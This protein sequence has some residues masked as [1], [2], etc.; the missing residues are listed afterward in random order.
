MTTPT[1]DV[2]TIGEGQIRL[3][4]NRGERLMS[5]RSVRMNPACSEANVA[6]LLSELKRKTLWTSSL[7]EGDL[8]EYVLSEYRSVGV[9]LSTMVRKPTSRIALYFMEPGEPPM[10]ANVIYDREYTPFRTTGIDEYDWDTILDT[11][12]IF[13]TGITAALT[14]TTADV[15]S[16]AADEAAKKGIDIALDVNFRSKLWSGEHARQVLEPIAKKA[17][18]LF[19][20]I[21]DAKHVFGIEGTG[22][23][24]VEELYRRF[25]NEYVVSTNHLDGPYLRNAEG[26]HKYATTT[27]PVVDRPGA[28]D[29]FVSAT[30]HGFLSHDVECGVKW[31]QKAAEFALTHMGDLTRM[32]PEELD[33]PL[34]NDINR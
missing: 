16:F 32:R 24:V 12:L 30:L 10:P 14:D 8:G 31:G 15:V 23:E 21:K 2:S 27:V 26:V 11:R 3:T 33:I 4:V 7:P 5:A 13:L 34:G 9:D 20:S 25:G 17:R 22:E 19:C 6:G 29:S 28:G 18:I 1:Y